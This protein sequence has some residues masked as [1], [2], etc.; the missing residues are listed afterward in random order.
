VGKGV[1]MS[2]KINI[3][4]LV[5]FIVMAVSSFVV[6]VGEAHSASQPYF[7][8][9]QDVN[10]FQIEVGPQNPSSQDEIYLTARWLYHAT[11]SCVPEISS[12]YSIEE[13]TISVQIDLIFDLSWGCFDIYLGW[14]E[15]SETL[16]LGVLPPGDYT[17]AVTITG[18]Y[19]YN[20][21]YFSNTCDYTETNLNVTLAICEGDFDEDGDVDGVDLAIFAADFGRTD[22]VNE[23]TFCPCDIDNDCDVDDINFGMCSYPLCD[24][25]GDGDFDG[26]D[27]AVCAADFGRDDCCG[28]CPADFDGDGD[29]DGSDLAVFADDFGRTECPL[30]PLIP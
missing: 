18:I 19:L 15:Q 4:N 2:T 13:N 6:D 10:D 20:S 9:C 8:L 29:V 16:E 17:V 7:N 21:F 30:F 23:I 5:L 25:D 3:K 1:K 11:T 28:D 12:A 14:I 22:C 27:L 24:F 26:A